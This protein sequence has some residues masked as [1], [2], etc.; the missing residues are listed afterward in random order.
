MGGEDDAGGVVKG[1]SRFREFFEGDDF[2]EE[3]LGRFFGGEEGGEGF[4]EF[5]RES[6]FFFVLGSGGRE[7][8]EVFCEPGGAGF[9]QSIVNFELFKGEIIQGSLEIEGTGVHFFREFHHGHGKIGVAAENG[10]LNRGS[11][12]EVGK[13]GG[14]DV[15]NAFGLEEFQ[16]VIF[17]QNAEGG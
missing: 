3:R 16:N 6:G 14:V 9:G 10:R 8:F 15:Q 13:K 2:A 17:N 7:F 1:V 12:T 11:A 4:V 5:A